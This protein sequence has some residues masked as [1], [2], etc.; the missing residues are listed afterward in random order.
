MRGDVNIKYGSAVGSSSVDHLNNIESFEFVSV[1]VT[2]CCLCWFRDLERPARISCSNKCVF[3]QFHVFKLNLKM[4]SC[5]K[6]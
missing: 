3:F 2:W 6:A 1:N 4:G 5:H